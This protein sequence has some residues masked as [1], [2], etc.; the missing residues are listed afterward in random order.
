[1]DKKAF[2]FCKSSNQTP[3]K[4]QDNNSI[5]KSSLCYCSE[6]YNIICRKIYPSSDITHIFKNLNLK[7]TSLNCLKEMENI[8]IYECNQNSTSNDNFFNISNP[9]CQNDKRSIDQNPK[10]TS[11]ISTYFK[12]KTMEIFPT[13]FENLTNSTKKPINFKSSSGQS[14][15]YVILFL[16]ACCI[17][18]YLG[19]F[20][21]NRFKLK[22]RISNRFRR[23]FKRISS[24]KFADKVTVETGFK[25]FTNETDADLEEISLSSPSSTNGDEIAETRL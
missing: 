6:L 3:L 21:C 24:R 11:D 17:L 20:L 22:R 12:N 23:S 16:I 13:T 15:I 9:I 2:L 1:M 10:N 4:V 8:E 14:L 19:S 18:G 7:N 5:Q 25:E